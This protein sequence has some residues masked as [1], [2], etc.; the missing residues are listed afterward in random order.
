M[1]ASARRVVPRVLR[2]VWNGTNAT[3][4][5][6]GAVTSGPGELVTVSIETD[7]FAGAQGHAEQQNLGIAVGYESLELTL[8]KCTAI[9]E[10]KA[11]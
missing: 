5:V 1:P 2:I 4:T 3:V 8:C 9:V 7:T 11:L 10:K 6:P